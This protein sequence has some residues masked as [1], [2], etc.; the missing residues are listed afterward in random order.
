[1]SYLSC[2]K[3]SDKTAATQC[4]DGTKAVCVVIAAYNA[5][6][7]IA[8]AVRSALAQREVAEIVVV[9]DASTD[10]TIA[11]ANAADDATGRLKILA[12]RI[13]SGP[14]AARNLGIAAS[15]SPLIALL[16]ADDFYLPERFERML[17]VQDW[18]LIADNIAFVDED[19]IGE[20]CEKDVKR[21][22]ESTWEVSYLDFVEGNHSSPQKYRSEISFMKPLIK[23]EIIDRTQTFYNENL[24]LGEDFIFYS[25]LMIKG[26]RL[27]CIDCC[28]YIAVVRKG[29]LS[30]EHSTQDIANFFKADL[31]LLNIEHNDQNI[32]KS[33][34]KHHKQLADRLHLRRI[35]DHRRSYGRI[36]A[37]WEALKTPSM[38]ISLIASILREKVKFKNPPNQKTKYLF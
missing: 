11:A 19:H 21:N 15:V 5:E 3:Q 8:R 6:M 2:A 28:G 1:M 37:I 38:F 34:E 33:L 27:K 4:F 16:D 30:G 36:S 20:F 31:D 18:D 25:E 9:D 13:N 23:R 32:Q 7:T 10:H 12:L 22:S 35:L 17:Q 14:A 26:A 29:S 24:R